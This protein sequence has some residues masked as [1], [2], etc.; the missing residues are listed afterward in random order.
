M[1]LRFALLLCERAD[2]DDHVPD[3]VR[4][5]ATAIGGHLAFAVLDDVK[6]FSVGEVFE[7]S[8][9]GVVPGGRLEIGDVAFTVSGCSVAHGAV[10]SVHLFGVG[11]GFWRGLYRVDH[12]RCFRGNCRRSGGW[13][14]RLLRRACEE[15]KRGKD[16]QRLQHTSL[17]LL[18]CRAASYALGEFDG[19]LYFQVMNFFD[20]SA[21]WLLGRSAPDHWLVS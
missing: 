19:K 7:G 5:H 17:L 12:M 4:F 6:D 21:F 11:L 2:K 1:W 15:Q 10:V 8:R 9:I 20:N 14:S 16:E 13:C 3:V 18:Y